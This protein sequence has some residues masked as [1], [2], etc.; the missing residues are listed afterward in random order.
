[1][2]LKSLLLPDELESCKSIPFHFLIIVIAG[3]GPK[4]RKLCLARSYR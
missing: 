3:S 1:M 4:G 2:I